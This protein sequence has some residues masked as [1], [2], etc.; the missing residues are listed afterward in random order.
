MAPVA[1][2]PAPPYHAT[3]LAPT[4]HWVTRVD[5]LRRRSRTAP[6][7]EDLTE[8]TGIPL[9]PEGADMM[10]TRYLVG[11]R[12]AAGQRVLELG[13]GAGQGVGLLGA[14]ARRLV[15]GDYSHE[16]LRRGRSHYGGRFPCVRLSA[17]R[18]PFRD[19]VFDVVL[20]FEASYYVRDTDAAFDEA[21]RVLAPGGTLLLVNANPE[22]PDFIRSP[23]SVTYHTSDGFRRALGGRGLHVTVEGA[24]AITEATGR[25]SRLAPILGLA[26]RMLETLHL[27]PRTLRGRARLKRLV[28]GKLPTVPAELREGFGTEAPRV[29]VSPGAVRGYKVLYVTAR[30]PR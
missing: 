12:L 15:G 10:Y 11:M 6:R 29:S 23:H 18:L 28:Y 21:A 14:R 16:L 20:F 4:G 30:K 22:R 13:C 7:F 19:A 25:R 3:S 5:Q 24:F 27:V 1:P 17:D 2:A 26:R 8:T 9:S